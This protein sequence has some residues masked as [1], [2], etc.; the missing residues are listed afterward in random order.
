MKNI[1]DQLGI[2]YLCIAKINFGAGGSFGLEVQLV[3]AAA[4][5]T[6]TTVNLQNL[7]RKTIASSMLNIGRELLAALGDIGGGT[8]QAAGAVQTPAAALAGRGHQASGSAQ[9]YKGREAERLNFY[10][11]LRYILPV[12]PGAP[13]WAIGGETGYIWHNN[14]YL[15]IEGGGGGSSRN[16]T[17]GYGLNL[18]GVIDLSDDLQLALGGFLGFWGEE[19]YRENIDGTSGGHEKIGFVGPSVKLRWRFAEFSYRL[20]IGPKHEYGYG[21]AGGGFINQFTSGFYFQW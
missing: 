19:S 2:H 20:L 4:G 10:F 18:G 14:F 11:T 15:G 21:H 17:A 9:T 16:S 5:K 3:N 7:D 1:A 6:V 13:K 8:A 12:T